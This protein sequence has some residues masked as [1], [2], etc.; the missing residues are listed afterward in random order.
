MQLIRNA[1]QSVLLVTMLGAFAS[2]EAQ[3]RL[4]GGVG[5]GAA[6]TRINNESLAITG[7]TGST[8]TKRESDTSGKVFA[9]YQANKNFAVEAGYV[10]L[11]KTSA[12]RSLSAP[13]VGSAAMDSRN[14]GWFVDLVGKAPIGAS[15]FSL[16]G[17]LGLVA[18]ETSKNLSVA[19]SV[20]P[21]PGAASTYK[22]RESNLK[23]G[24]GAQYDI[25]K[26]MAARGEIELY[27]KLG[28]DATTGENDVG[29]FSMNLLIKFQ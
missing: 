21:I 18:S 4:Y 12:T 7:A 28:K 5:I 1:V 11:G 23:Y 17:K 15:D 2:A 24:A 10:D 27:R 29:L 16:I 13:S 25:S 22:E 14:T 3:E 9:G 20:S 6:K 8:L 19:G 26:T